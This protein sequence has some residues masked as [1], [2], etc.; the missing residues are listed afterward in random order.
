MVRSNEST[1]LGRKFGSKPSPAPAS[2]QVLFGKPTQVL[3]P[4]NRGCGNVG[5]AAASGAVRPLTPIRNAVL[6]APVLAIDGVVP[7]TQPPTIT[8]KHCTG[9]IRPVPRSGTSTRSTPFKRP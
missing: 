1:T 5:D 7:G 3:K 6:F 8:L 9:W 2:T 4:G